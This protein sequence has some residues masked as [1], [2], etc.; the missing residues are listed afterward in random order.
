MFGYFQLRLVEDELMATTNNDSVYSIYIFIYRL[1]PL[2][3][4]YLSYEKYNM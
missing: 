3:A 4:M 2:L 1:Y